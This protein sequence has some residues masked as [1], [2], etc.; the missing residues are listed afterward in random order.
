MRFLLPGLAAALLAVSTLSAELP[1]KAIPLE[2]RTHDGKQV[3]LSDLK[4]KAAVV[5]AFTCNSCPY[6]VDYEDRLIALA[7]KYAGKKVA[8]VAINV[9]KV[10]DDLPPEMAKKA[11]KKGFTFP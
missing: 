6:A 8:V 2:F 7:K 10:K 11:R 9:N 1:R 4:G 5:V 3:A